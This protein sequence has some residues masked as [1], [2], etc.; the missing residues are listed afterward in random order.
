MTSEPLILKWYE[1]PPERRTG[2]FLRSVQPSGE[3]F[4][5]VTSTARRAQ[6][7]ITGTIAAADLQRLL[8]TIRDIRQKTAKADH[9]GVQAGWVGL[10]AAGKVARPEIILR[11][12]EGDEQ[13]SEAARLFLKVVDLLRPY[14]K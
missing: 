4:G 7:T 5:E 13:C 8:D 3:F 12:Y 9:L 6:R 10:L 11:Y 14:I 2:W 1:G